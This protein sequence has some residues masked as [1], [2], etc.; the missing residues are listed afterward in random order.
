MWPETAPFS[1]PPVLRGILWVE[2]GRWIDRDAIASYLEMRDHEAPWTLSQPEP[3]LLKSVVPESREAVA[4]IL[5]R[6]EGLKVCRK[7]AGPAR[8]PEYEAIS[9]NQTLAIGSVRLRW[10]PFEVPKALGVGGT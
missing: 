9:E 1:G 3:D 6:P 4:R 7:T 5:V 2:R 8:K 10:V